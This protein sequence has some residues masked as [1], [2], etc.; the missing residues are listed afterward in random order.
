MNAFRLI[1]RLTALTALFCGAH[2]LAGVLDVLLPT[3]ELQTI[4]VTDMTEAGRQH[5]AASPEHPIYYTAV[6]GGYH[7]FGGIRAGE[8]PVVRSAVNK[9]MIDVLAKQGYLPAKAGQQPDIV[10][11]WTWGTMNTESQMMPS[12]LGINSRTMNRAQLLRFLG[13]SKLGLMDTA[14]PEQTLSPDLYYA[15]GD[16]RALMDAATTDLYV[17]AILA[18][19]TKLDSHGRAILLWNTRMSCPSRGSWLPQ[20][21]PAMAVMAGPFI[22]RETERPMWVKATDKFKPSVKIGDLKLVEYLRG[23]EKAVVN[24]G[25]VK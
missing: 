23:T 4:T 18:Y 2:A 20:A 13:G 14:F 16:Q 10:L 21:L 12:S 15:G 24:V 19:D 8:K 22:G 9:T 25:E 5:R 7:D 1:V 17:A 11:V 6:S 3:D